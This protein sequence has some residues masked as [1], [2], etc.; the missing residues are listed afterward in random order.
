[1]LGKKLYD[2]RKRLESTLRSL[3]ERAGKRIGGLASSF[4]CPTT[5]VWTACFLLLL[6]ILC[7]CTTTRVVRPALPPQAQA[8]PIPTFEGQTYRDVIQYVI[9]LKEFAYQS[10]ADKAAIRRVY[11]E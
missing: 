2:S 7:G 8:R 11:G 1:M 3:I 9:Q 5:V 6:L 10:E 4:A